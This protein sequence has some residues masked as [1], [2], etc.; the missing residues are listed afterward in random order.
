ML[1][2]SFY[3]LGHY[4]HQCRAYSYRSVPP[5]VLSVVS[6]KEPQQFEQRHT[7]CVNDFASKFIKNWF[8]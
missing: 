4:V 1:I 8:N 6:Y 7:Q 5:L 2:F 3:I